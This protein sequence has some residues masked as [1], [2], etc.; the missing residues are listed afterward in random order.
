MTKAELRS[1]FRQK[2]QVLPEADWQN[3]CA[4][5]SERFFASFPFKPDA[6]IGTFL[7]IES[8]KEV[9]TWLIIQR[10]WQDFPLVRVAAPV[11]NLVAGTMEN[12]EIRPETVFSKNRYGIPEPSP[13]SSSIIHH[14]SFDSILIPL[15][16]FD[17]TGNRVGYG[18]GFYDRFL[19]KC[20]PDCLK[21]GLSLFDPVDVIE[22]V[23]EDDIR[24]NF[25]VTPEK[26]WCFDGNAD[27]TDVT[28]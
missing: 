7:P 2:R 20:R 24:L 6:V 1:A 16:A 19:V 4:G 13:N 3:R 21:I 18:G 9:D 17:K 25:C 8:Q 15:L 10:L 23:Y 22:D 27:G 26:V 28:D 5:I 14:S 11:T 12:Y